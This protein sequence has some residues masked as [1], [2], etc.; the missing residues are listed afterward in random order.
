MRFMHVVAASVFA[1]SLAST[2]G[3]AQRAPVAPDTLVVR[4]PAEAT[5][6]AVRAIAAAAPID[7]SIP[8]GNPSVRYVVITRKEIGAAELHEG[9]TDVAF[10]QSGSGVLRTG[11]TLAGGRRTEPWEWRGAT[12]VGPREQPA[13]PGD[14]F[15]IPAGLAHQW[16]P[17][18]G[19]PL[20]YLTVKVPPD[21]SA[22][23]RSRR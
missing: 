21:R 8:T 19:A 16:R 7:R 14:V 1:A 5:A 15:V 6:A 17:N 22:P 20:T 11:R 10:V 2:P 18:P 4:V 9:W 3:S 23:G 12:I 13:Q